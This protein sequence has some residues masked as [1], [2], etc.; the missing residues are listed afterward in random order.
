MRQ[1]EPRQQI[2]DHLA[3][4]RQLPCCVCGNNIETEA[5]HIRYP[6][7]TVAKP[8][9]GMGQKSDDCW[10][11]PLCSR[12]HRMQHASDE[13]SFWQGHGID[14]IRIALALWRVSGDV[15]KGC[16]IATER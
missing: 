3:Y 14:P 2:P 5:A 12:H 7:R 8:L 16:Q 6:D 9:T 13:L 4:I 1:R 11:V 15:E 10:A